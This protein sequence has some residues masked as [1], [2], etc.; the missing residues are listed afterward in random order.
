MST[1]QQ[2]YYKILS[3]FSLCEDPRKHR[4]RHPLPN[5]IVIVI[6]AVLCGEEGWDGFYE[7]AQDKEN[8]LSQFLDLKHGIPSPD[9]LRR[10]IERLDP[11]SFLE[12]FLSWA[13]EMR[14]RI[15]EQICIDGKTLK[16]TASKGKVLHLVSAF[17]SDNGI[18]LGITDAKGKGGEIP[19]IKELLDT[20]VLKEKDLVTIDAIGCQKE[21]INM[22]RKQ[23]ADYLIALKRNQGKLWDEAANFFD[24][25]QLAEDEAPVW[26]NI[27]DRK[28]HGRKES[29]TIWVTQDLNWLPQKK[30]WK[31]LRSLVCIK[32]HWEEKGKVKQETRY[33]ITSA[34]MEPKE[35]GHRIR[36]HWSIENEYHWHLDVNFKED[37]SEIGARSN[38]ILRVAR[39]IALHLL[40]SEPTKRLSIK[41]K[42]RKCHRSETFLHQ[43]L[44]VGNF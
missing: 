28:E 25:V 26:E 6:L 24:Q 39:T 43:V 16:K 29:H 38:R 31:D 3:H 33:Y 22:I 13:D 37:D 44:L 12:A 21:I 10:V 17:A 19:A 7:W 2:T 34:N 11:D 9:T 4:I 20:L 42:K 23:R 18:V 15:P 35:F 36:R 1:H 41:Q 30:E 8:F 14:Q 5:I 27:A 40:K 32:R